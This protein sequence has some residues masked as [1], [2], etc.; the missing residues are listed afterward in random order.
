MAV[1]NIYCKQSQLSYI[2]KSGNFS[3]RSDEIFNFILNYDRHAKYFYMQLFQQFFL[4]KESFLLTNQA[5]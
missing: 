2:N 3:I 1:T 4:E 5:K